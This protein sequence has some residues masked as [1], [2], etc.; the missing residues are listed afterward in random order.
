MQ[1]THMY[2]LVNKTSFKH[3]WVIIVWLQIEAFPSGS[4]GC[5]IKF[6]QKSKAVLRGGELLA[7]LS[8]L[9]EPHACDQ[10]IK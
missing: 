5:E 3:N 4:R 9:L 10:L 2:L 7:A 1:F 8:L 6:L